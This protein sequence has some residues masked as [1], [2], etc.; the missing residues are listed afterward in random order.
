MK[1][2]VGVNRKARGMALSDTSG[3]ASAF[4]H[5]WSSLTSATCAKSRGVVSDTA[6]DAASEGL[7][8][9]RNFRTSE[10]LGSRS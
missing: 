6:H 2:N 8:G 7:L 1:R 4:D 9:V 3:R 10:E 5:N